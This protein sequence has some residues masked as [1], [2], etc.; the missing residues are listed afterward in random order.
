MSALSKWGLMVEP[1]LGLDLKE[2]IGLAQRAERLGFGYIFRSD[3]LLSTSGRQSKKSAEC[4][5]SLGAIAAKTGKMKLGP[6]VSPVG[7]RNPALLA[8]MACTLHD[9]SQG[10]LVLGVGAGWF[11]DEYI[12]HGY[13]FP[14]FRDRVAQLEEALLVLRPLLRGERVDHEGKHFKVHAECYPKP[15]GKVHLI[16]GGRS[17]Q[18]VRLAAKH[19]DEWDIFSPSM[20]T[21]R[22]LKPV[23]DSNSSE[24][25]VEVSVMTGFFIAE[26]KDG[27]RKS[28]RAFQQRFGAAGEPDKAILT[29]REGGSLVGQVGEFVSQLNELLEAGVDRVYFQ[30][31]DPGNLAA[32][33]LLARTLKE[34]L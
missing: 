23:L 29:L 15:R 16:V 10:R 25:K 26:T 1:Q 7:F 17:P 8:E 30:V 6:L 11:R 5:T 34:E 14:S 24:R 31:L 19:A 20:E 28:V 22:K 33:R 27:L 2:T 21:F 18:V 4:W 3:H 13:G 9:Y 12:A 32:I